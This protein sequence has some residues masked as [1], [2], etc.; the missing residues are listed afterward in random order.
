MEAFLSEISNVPAAEFHAYLYH[1]KGM[2]AARHLFEVA[3]GLD[4][5]VIGE[6]QILGQVT[7]AS[8]WR[9]DSLRRVPS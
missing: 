3:A 6:P 7:R 2:E 8:N 4:S 1:F 5:L 9:A